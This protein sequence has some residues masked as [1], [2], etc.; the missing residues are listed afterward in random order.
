MEGKWSNKKPRHQINKAIASVSDVRTIKRELGNTA[1]GVA[2]TAVSKPGKVKA[3]QTSDRWEMISSF[4]LS[5]LSVCGRSC[6]IPTEVVTATDDILRT[7]QTPAQIYVF[8]TLV[9]SVR[10]A[11]YGEI[12]LINFRFNFSTRLKLGL[13]GEVGCFIVLPSFGDHCKLI[14]V[15]NGL[16]KLVRDMSVSFRLWS[17]II[18]VL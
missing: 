3:L 14:C 17:V 4:K 11:K 2:S 18:L 6:H 10:R 9:Q 7:K 16:G 8:P 12:D 15:W 13:K 1:H 5:T